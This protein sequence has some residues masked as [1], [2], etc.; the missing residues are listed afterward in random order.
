MTITGHLVL[1]ALGKENGNYLSYSKEKLVLQKSNKGGTIVFAI[2]YQDNGTIALACQG[3]EKGLYLSHTNGQ[4]SLKYWE[5]GDDQLWIKYD[6]GFGN[7]AFECSGNKKGQFLSHAFNEIWL[8]DGYEGEGE[9]WKMENSPESDYNNYLNEYFTKS[10]ICVKELCDQLPRVTIFTSLD[11][12]PNKKLGYF[13]GSQVFNTRLQQNPLAIVYCE[14]PEHVQKAF[15]I[16]TK[17][18]IPIRVRAGGHD[19]EGESSGTNVVTIDVSKMT[20]VK[21]DK[22]TK[23]AEIGAGNRF[24]CLTSKLADKDVMIAHGTC[25][26]VC[27][28]GYTLGGGWGPWTRKVGMNCEH[29]KGATMILGDGSEVRVD[30][31]PKDGHVPELLWALRG[32]GGLSYGIVTELRIQ[33]FDLPKELIKFELHWNHYDD[34]EKYPK[35][36]FPTLEI[37]KTWEEVIKSE[38]TSKLIGTNF[39]INGRPT[40]DEFDYKKISHG[41]CMY[42]YWE[43][44][45]DELV[46]FVYE[47][48]KNVLPMGIHIDGEGGVHTE[49][50]EKYIPLVSS[51]TPLTAPVKG[52][53][54]SFKIKTAKEFYINKNGLMSSWDRES[55]AKTQEKIKAKTR[56]KGK[57][58]ATLS[59][60]PIPP[61][62]DDPA[63]HKITSRFVNHEGLNDEGYK[64]FLLSLTSSLIQPENRGLGIFTY[65]TLGA[66]VGDYYNSKIGKNNPTAFPYKD[67]LYTIQY[68]AW[69]NETNYEKIDPSH[70]QNDSVYEN[71]NR[72]MDWIDVARNFN[73]PNTSGSF[74]SFKDNSIPTSVYFDKNYDKLKKIKINFSKD[75]Y[76]H[77]RT[78]KTI[79]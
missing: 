1:E 36:D 37:L 35:D 25:A 68:Q 59:G 12:E 14:T 29:L 7:V 28:T 70:F 78:R 32:G 22:T 38:N 58:A 79:I 50:F 57:E 75:P 65:V 11:I 56:V 77:F 71:T 19:H 54:I 9:L 60:V 47:W 18:Q 48:F 30:E 44:N 43:G 10:E 20:S 73:I 45:C 24:I 40:V 17:N 64:Q 62:L 16:A 27:I 4:L 33:T 61:D 41:C 66:I 72:A 74:I 76:N 5:K 34:K 52:P 55:F 63:P 31:D 42:G 39:K 3:C 23:I 8:Q 6:K 46:T 67:K 51:K 13:K 21:I 26:T 53:E 69:W 49:P 15:D 2:E